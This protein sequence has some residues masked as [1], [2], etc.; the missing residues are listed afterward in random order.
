[1]DSPNPTIYPP[2]TS[3]ASSHRFSAASA[4]LQPQNT[5]LHRMCKGIATFGG[6][7]E[8]KARASWVEGDSRGMVWI[9]QVNGG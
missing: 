2:H 3:H 9:L 4:A 6:K 1:M 8:A 5:P 7:K